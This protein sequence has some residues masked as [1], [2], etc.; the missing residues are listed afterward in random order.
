MAVEQADVVVIGAGLAG[1]TAAR[2]LKASGRTVV[3]VE[4]RDRVGGRTLNHSLTDGSTVELGGQW[5]GPTQTAVLHLAEELG[6]E[7]YP[8]HT[9][10]KHL[11]EY[12]GKAHRYT[13]SIPFVPSPSLAEGYLALKRLERMA[14]TVSASSPWSTP[15]SEEWDG[16][17]LQSW[18]DRHVRTSGGRSLVVLVCQAVLAA[19]PSEVSLLH[20][21]AYVASAGGIDPLI[22]TVGGAQERRVV[23]GS[24]RL[25]LAM[26]AEFGPD[27]LRTSHPVDAIDHVDDQVAVYIRSKDLVI[28]ARQVIVAMS[29]S[30]AGRITYSP[31]LPPAR[32]QLTQRAPNGSV[33]K[34]MA[35]YPTPFWRRLGFSGQAFLID[36]PLKMVYDNS[37]HDSDLG[38]LVTFFEGGSARTASQAGTRWRRE[39]VLAIFT[40]LFGPAAQEPAEVIERD[41]SAEEFTRG[42]YG[43]VM[44]P[45]T[46]TSVGPALRQ[47][48]GAIYWASAETAQEWM[49]YMDGAVR[50][51]QQAADDIVTRR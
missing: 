43:A 46:W 14:R 5:I 39:T 30:M 31:P 13:G 41:W 23:G 16:Q 6:L 9:M 34:F 11:I 35:I 10:G 20:V 37:P 36:G 19:D 24:Q 7:T 21:L 3:V 15:R 47:H 8:T 22:D 44:P 50:A 1:L 40:R 51:G 45:N 25:T 48:A 18:I 29:P 38:V 28:N 33:T 32:D 49:G 12:R 4:A 26:A 27:E 17:T 42:C 2:R